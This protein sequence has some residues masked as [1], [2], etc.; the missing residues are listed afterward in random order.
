MRIMMV[1]AL[2]FNEFF[3]EKEF[4]SVNSDSSETY[5]FSYVF[6]CFLSVLDSDYK[7]IKLRNFC[8]PLIDL[9]FGKIKYSSGFSSF[10]KLCNGFS[11]LLNFSGN[12][13]I[14][15]VKA[16][17]FY[18]NIETVAFTFS[19]GFNIVVKN[20]YRRIFSNINITEYTVFPEHILTLKIC[21]V[22]PTGNNSKKLILSLC[23]KTV[24]F[25]FSTVVA[26][27]TVTDILTVNIKRKA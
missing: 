4:F 7:V 26:A 11:V 24:K 19:E 6:M 9:H 22:T 20:I 10:F 18:S 23:Y 13:A 8:T 25:K 12:P 5:S 27:L 15:S 14:L 17:R 3:I 16:Q 2:K 1:Y 21:T